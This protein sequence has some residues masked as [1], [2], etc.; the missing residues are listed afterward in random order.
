MLNP[1]G[2]VRE[3]E[4]P[5]AAA[6]L[7][8]GTAAARQILAESKKLLAERKKA[9]RKLPGL[10]VVV[11]E[12]PRARVNIARLKK[13][14]CDAAGIYCELHLLSPLSVQAEVIALVEKLNADPKITGINIH[15]L[16]PHLDYRA[17]VAAMDPA[18]DVEGVHP[19]NLGGFLLWG[20]GCVPFTP[21]GVMKLIE[22]TGL[23]IAGKRAT[24]VGR[25]P[26]VGLP[27]AFLLMEHGAAVTIAHSRSRRL[28]EVTKKADILVVATGHPEMIT[29]RMIKEGA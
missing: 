20:E 17:V 18:K 7:L 24:V 25:S 22:T 6:H 16:P 9:N 27:V 1:D 12:S 21:R 29:G 15:P 13:R 14:V 19:Q 8:D 23:E 10:A 11:V 3:V 2:T 26:H 4:G 28:E 5:L